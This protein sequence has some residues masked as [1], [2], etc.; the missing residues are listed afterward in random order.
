MR[1]TFWKLVER[2]YWQYV[3]VPEHKKYPVPRYLLR[4]CYICYRSYHGHFGGGGE[5]RA[6]RERRKQDTKELKVQ[7]P[8]CTR[9]LL[10]LQIHSFS[11]RLCPPFQNADLHGRPHLIPVL[12]GFREW[13]A[14][15]G[16]WSQGGEWGLGIITLFPFLQ[17]CFRIAVSL[18]WRFW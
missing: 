2:K 9:C 13:A 3:I 4:L 10:F 5:T 18:D 16:D 17:C 11:T 12:S 7:V 15:T 1:D 8:P 14:L 6:G